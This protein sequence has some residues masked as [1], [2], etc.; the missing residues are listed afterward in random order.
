MGER[1]CKVEN[2]TS[3][4]PFFHSF[5]ISSWS[6]TTFSF[7]CFTFPKLCICVH[8]LCLPSA[9]QT[10]LSLEISSP[11]APAQTCPFLKSTSSPYT[12]PALWGAFRAAMPCSIPLNLLNCGKLFWLLWVQ[13][14][15][16]I[17]NSLA[18]LKTGS[19][20]VWSQN[21]GTE[22]QPTARCYC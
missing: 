6:L 18:G 5:A 16:K 2:S 12:W 11:S 9:T 21:L 13:S 4:L 20:N 14:S 22:S 3:G 17:L 10:N 7:T 8:L 19:M 15:E 1:E